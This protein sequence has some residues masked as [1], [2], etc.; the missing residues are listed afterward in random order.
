MRNRPWR[1]PCHR[2]DYEFLQRITTETKTQGTEFVCDKAYYVAASKFFVQLTS[3]F[4]H[5]PHL[6][7]CHFTCMFLTL[8]YKCENC[9][10]IRSAECSDIRPKDLG[11]SHQRGGKEICQQIQCSPHQQ[12]TVSCISS[13][14]YYG[15]AS[16]Y[17]L[18]TTLFVA[19]VM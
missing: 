9:A 19:S 14:L 18:N 3:V 10:F 16:M 1:F 8:L 6:Y 13:R 15:K 12:T 5:I 11:V 7:F 4:V 17:I 2:K